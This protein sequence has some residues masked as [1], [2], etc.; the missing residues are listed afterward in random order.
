ML[1]LYHHSEIKP[2]VGR[3]IARGAISASLTGRSGGWFHGPNEKDEPHRIRGSS[4]P[5]G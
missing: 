5:S 3:M 4:G 2:V 1:G